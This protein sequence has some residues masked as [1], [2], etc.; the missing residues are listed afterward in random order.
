MLRGAF[1]T[2]N[3]LN[4]S[5]KSSAD[6]EEKWAY[7]RLLSKKSATP[8]GELLVAF[9]DEYHLDNLRNATS[10]QLKDFVKMKKI[11]ENDLE[12]N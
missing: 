4:L 3:K 11:D 8:Y 6:S 2:N 9:M 7:V 5:K 10:E 12:R 1:M